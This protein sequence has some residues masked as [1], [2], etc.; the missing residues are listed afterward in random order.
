MSTI[1]NALKKSEELRNRK[2]PTQ[3]LASNHYQYPV[4]EETTQA[5]WPY[6]TIAVLSTSLICGGVFWYLS[7][8]NDMASE[9][10]SPAALD[11]EQWIEQTAAQS[12]KQLST[13]LQP[14][15]EQLVAE[16][17]GQTEQALESATPAAKPIIK[18]EAKPV[19]PD[20]QTVRSAEP[21]EVEFLPEKQFET[22]PLPVYVSSQKPRA[23]VEQIQPKVIEPVDPLADLDLSDTSP[24]LAAKIRLA[25]AGEQTQAVEPEAPNEIDYSDVSDTV[26][27]KFQRA[28]AAQENTPVAE[29]APSQPMSAI[30]VS[31]LPDDIQASI[32]PFAY[33]SHVYSSL[34]EKRSVRF[35][36]T[37]FKE[38]DSV[39]TP[40][41]TLLE[42]RPDYVIMRYQ[43][44]SFSVKSME[45]WKGY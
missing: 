35:N 4:A 7:A 24:E 10:V 29:P 6:V 23:R 33:N 9:Q 8:N 15:K 40:D 26:A 2:I 3:S 34:V 14:P 30:P 42:I 39:F 22:V 43:N 31:N 1:L 37:E 16:R 44:Q 18:P 25:L 12:S 19:K 11:M 21:A 17:Q 38:G 45:D 41:L 5:I 36:G 27:E 20:A 28:L 13:N 32:P